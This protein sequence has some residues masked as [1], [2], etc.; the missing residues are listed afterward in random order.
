MLRCRTLPAPSTSVA[1]NGDSAEPL[2]S[3]L[4]PPGLSFQAS[5]LVRDLLLHPY[6]YL[7]EFVK[8]ADVL[9][10]KKFCGADCISKCEQPPA[11]SLSNGNVTNLVIG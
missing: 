8:R 4:P 1:A 11:N 7:H 5:S 10:S 2:R 6:L 3:V 9:T